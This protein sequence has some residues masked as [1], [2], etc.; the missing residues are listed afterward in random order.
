M[1]SEPHTSNDARPARSRRLP[2]MRWQG[3]MVAA[4]MAAV[5]LVAL[6]V[7]G[8]AVAGFPGSSGAIAFESNRSGNFHIYTVMNGGTV[9]QLTSEAG[10]DYRPAWSAEG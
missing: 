5:A 9:T 7:S 8:S 10:N 6:S 4:G 2:E 1:G 3:G